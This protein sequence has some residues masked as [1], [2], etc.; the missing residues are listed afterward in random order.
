MLIAQDNC[1]NENNILV[2]LQQIFQELKSSQNRVDYQ[3]FWSN[4]VIPELNV[5]VTDGWE[6][7][8]FNET[9]C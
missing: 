7:F 8:T 2:Y 5:G 9:P 6:V 1:S 4:L 3:S